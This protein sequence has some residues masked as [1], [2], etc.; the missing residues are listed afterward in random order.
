VKDEILHYAETARTDHI[1]LRVQW[2]GLAHDVALG[3]IKGIG[4]IIAALS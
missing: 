1:L 4:R 3:N 2:P